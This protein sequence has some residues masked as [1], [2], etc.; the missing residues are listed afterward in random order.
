MGSWVVWIFLFFMALGVAAV[1]RAKMRAGSAQVEE[2]AV[3]RARRL[4]RVTPESPDPGWQ[5]LGREP[6]AD[7]LRLRF[8]H[9][10]DP[11]AEATLALAGTDGPFRNTLSNR[12]TI[13]LA[14]DFKTHH[15]HTGGYVFRARLRGTGDVVGREVRLK[16]LV[17]GSGRPVG[18]RIEHDDDTDAAVGDWIEF[19]WAEVLELAGTD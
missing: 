15:V 3:G 14:D 13:R 6:R 10:D 2:A 4:L 7:G 5:H 1:V 19:E 8:D 18:G 9:D 12:V 17:D 11:A 16:M